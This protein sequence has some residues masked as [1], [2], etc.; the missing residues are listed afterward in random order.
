MADAPE[1]HFV[2]QTDIRTVET[3]PELISFRIASKRQLGSNPQKPN[4][5]VEYFLEPREAWSPVYV[6]KAM[7]AIA[8]A[9]NLLSAALDS[10]LA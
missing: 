8:L 4:I 5:P 1:P 10:R 9:R 7:D 2:V 6:L 3:R